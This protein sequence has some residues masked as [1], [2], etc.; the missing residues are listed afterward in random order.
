MLIIMAILICI[1]LTTCHHLHTTEC[2]DSC[3]LQLL[4]RRQKLKKPI[5]PM[6]HHHRLPQSRVPNDR[7]L[8]KV[9]VRPPGH[10]PPRKRK[11]RRDPPRRRIGLHSFRMAPSGSRLQRKSTPSTLPAVARTTKPLLWRLQFFGVSRCDRLASGKHSC[12]LQESLD[13]LVFSILG[14]RQL[15]HTKSLEK[16]S[17]QKRVRMGHLCRPRRPRMLSTLHGRLPSME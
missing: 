3:T 17:R 9:A 4:K 16:N 14:K 6:P 11:S 1:I 7:R 2:Q 15:L 10:R 5:Y 12:T 13:T 8:F